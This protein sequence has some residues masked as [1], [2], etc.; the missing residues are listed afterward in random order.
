MSRR[1]AVFKLLEKLA[2]ASKH[3]PGG[4]VAG[5]G[6]RKPAAVRGAA[7][8]FSSS[9]ALESLSTPP[10]PSP[11]TSTFPSTRSRPLLPA[12][13]LSQLHTRAVQASSSILQRSLYSHQRPRSFSAGATRSDVAAS[14]S[15]AA[16]TDAAEEDDDEPLDSFLAPPSVTFAS[17]G[18]D[19][20]VCDALA[21]AGIAHPSAV[22]V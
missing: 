13:T 5:A 18:I 2:M 19:S 9:R 10:R 15:A 3:F 12:S 6:T 22:Q 21:A 11:T 20:V 14:A 17:L 7:A 4:S 1:R 16:S 8:S